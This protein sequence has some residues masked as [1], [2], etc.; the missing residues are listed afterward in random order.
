MTYII[1]DRVKETTTSTGT[2]ALA[3]L[4]GMA[5][6]RAFSAVCA[7][8]DTCDICI[9]GGAEWEICEATWGTGNTLAR[10]AVIASSN[11]GAA[12]TFG[13]GTKEVFLVLPA[14]D[15]KR[16]RPFAGS[17]AAGT[18][19]L[20]FLPGALLAAA[21]AGALEYDGKA[22]YL[23]P[24]ARAVAAAFHLMS[25]TADFAGQNVATAQPFFEAANDTITLGANTAYLFDGAIEM[26][27]AAGATSHTI[28]VSFGGTVVAADIGWHVSCRD[29]AAST[30]TPIRPYN[31]HFHALAG[32]TVSVAATTVNSTTFLV[33]GMIR[34]GAGGTL[35]PQFQYS[36]APGGA[37]TI[38]RSSYMTFTPVGADTVGSVGPV[39]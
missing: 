35:I 1:E 28:A 11:G 17:A 7:N 21:E 14:Y 16:P 34:T 18:S 37:P 36:A 25:N 5:G 26:T 2:G 22:F 39:A 38:K 19:P 27:R 15:I 32:G 20:L 13:A 10:G 23:S 24:S 31:N 30:T 8:G 9:A 3:L 33:K 6:F 12:V 4:G 29:G